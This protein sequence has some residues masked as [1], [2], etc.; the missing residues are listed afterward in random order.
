MAVCAPVSMRVTM[1]CLAAGLGSL[2]VGFCGEARCQEKTVDPLEAA[3]EKDRQEV[4]KL[5]AAGE[6]TKLEALCNDQEKSR[7][8][9]SSGSCRL[10]VIVDALSEPT[11]R[12]DQEFLKHLETLQAWQQAVP[13]SQIARVIEAQAT[14]AHGWLAR[15]GGYVDE[16]APADLQRFESRSRK[17]AAILDDVQKLTKTP[18]TE[19]YRARVDVALGIG[20]K[21]QREWVEAALKID[22]CFREIVQQM[23]HALLP[24]WYGEPAELVD[25]AAAAADQ[26]REACGDMMYFVVAAYIY[27]FNGILFLQRFPLE[28]ERIHKGIGDYERLYPDATIHLNLFA[29]MAVIAHDFEAAREYFAKIDHRVDLKVWGSKAFY[30]DQ[31]LH[32]AADLHEGGQ[33]RLL[34]AHEGPIVA[35]SVSA[36]GTAAMTADRQGILRAHSLVGDG[37]SMTFLVNGIRAASMV[38]HF[39]SGLL[40]CVLADKPGILLTSVQSGESALLPQGKLKTTRIAFASTNR[41]MAAVDEA[42]QITLFKLPEFEVER[43][44]IPATRRSLSQ[45]VYSPDGSRLAVGSDKGLVEMID[46]TDGKTQA[47]WSTGTAKTITIAWSPDGKR[48]AVADRESMLRLYDADSQKL[49]ASWKAPLPFPEALAWSPDGKTL[50]IGLCGRR[51]EGRHAATVFLWKLS[52]KTP[53]P[54]K[55]HKMGVRCLSYVDSGK[56]VSAGYDWTLRI[57]KPE[58]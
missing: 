26:T 39:P 51:Y 38:V 9:Y 28:W 8:R 2:L 19:Y 33:E 55:G 31:K 29:R 25:F 5:L 13:A 4:R 16:V 58:P 24:Q 20:E 37:Q 3:R 27:D 57:W 35:L 46:T 18:G 23:A 12:N 32:L 21:P 56:L 44:I 49:T 50:A 30:E 48:L 42:G 22:P 1:L 14:L 45:L 47:T 41:Q 52:E 34:I 36:D 43:D 11:S 10:S 7:E 15:G 53:Q 17:A 6:F 40:A 54:L